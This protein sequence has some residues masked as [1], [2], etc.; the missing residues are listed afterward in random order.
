MSSIQLLL[1]CACVLAS[2]IFRFN[3]T[4]ALIALLP[5]VRW[6]VVYLCANCYWEQLHT[7]NEYSCSEVFIVCYWNNII[8][9]CRKTPAEKYTAVE[10]KAAYRVCI[11]Q[12]LAYINF[13]S[14]STGPG[15]DTGPLWSSVTLVRSRNIFW[16]GL[17][18]CTA[19]AQ[20][21]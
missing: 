4:T 8:C 2:F 19:F 6:S 17:G 16:T 20:D 13:T 14:V 15:P 10:G 5:L 12:Q 21:V 7:W 9:L 3:I 18:P 1:G 11:S